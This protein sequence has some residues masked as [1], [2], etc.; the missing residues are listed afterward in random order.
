MTKCRTCGKKLGEED[1]DILEYAKTLH[2]SNS[3]VLLIKSKTLS[4]YS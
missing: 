2:C 3:S 1:N 4:S